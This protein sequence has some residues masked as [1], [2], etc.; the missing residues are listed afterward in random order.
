[1]TSSRT[2]IEDIEMLDEEATRVNHQ[3]VA[4]L[5]ANE[6]RNSVCSFPHI[7]EIECNQ[8]TPCFQ[9]PFEM[10]H[11]LFCNASS[12]REYMLRSRDS[13][14]DGCKDV[15]ESSLQLSR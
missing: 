2:E 10:L 3:E 6:M 1:M 4:L 5:T 7:Q 11:V 12:W 8:V 14:S 9:L 15:R 13:C